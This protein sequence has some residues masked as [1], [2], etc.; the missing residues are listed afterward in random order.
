MCPL[1]AS[2]VEPR[3]AARASA[4]WAATAVA[5][6]EGVSAVLSSAQPQLSM[7][8]SPSSGPANKIIC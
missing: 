5:L 1:T 8:I 4:S 3:R 6:A 2:E 7:F